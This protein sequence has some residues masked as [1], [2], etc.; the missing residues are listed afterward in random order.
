M[1]DGR[2]A[3]YDGD[4]EDYERWLADRRKDDTEAPKRQS[5]AAE[6]GPDAAASG[7]S[8][9]DRK[10]RKRAEAA[11]RQ[12]ISPFRKQ[13]VTLEKQMDSMQAA[14]AEMDAE[15]TNPELY[16]DSGKQQLKTLLG[17][18]AE[19][20]QKMAAVEAQWLEVSE[21]VEALEAELES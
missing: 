4:L 6:D 17:R 1:N 18:Q 13:Q 2:V 10:V 3:E 16:S 9:D 19:A 8:A 12:K 5:V 21:T 15:L 20:R 7:E 11:V 14:L